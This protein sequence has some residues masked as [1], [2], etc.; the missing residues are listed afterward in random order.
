M[1][2]STQRI[3]TT[4]VGS[5]SRPPDLLAMIQAK[6]RGEPFDAGLYANRVKGAVARSSSG[7]PTP[8]STSSPMA[9]WILG[10]FQPERLPTSSRARTGS[11]DGSREHWHSGYHQWA[12]Q[13]PG[14]TGGRR[15]RVCGPFPIAGIGTATGH[16]QFAGGTF[17]RPSCRRYRQ[18]TLPIGTPTVY[19]TGE[20][21]ALPTRYEEY[22]AIVD[23]DP[24]ADRRSAARQ[25]L[26]DAPIDSPNAANGRPRASSS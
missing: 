24:L 6:E 11:G 22:Q 15:R 8:A 19:K 3:L 5:L 17:G 2:Q 13:M 23:A 1:K 12:A 21:S 18:P 7:R 14:A 9:K 10:S 16:R 4:H 26:G 25:P 20:S